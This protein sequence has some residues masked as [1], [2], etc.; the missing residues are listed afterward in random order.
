MQPL[1]GQARSRR[2]D[3]FDI[4]YMIQLQGE[5]TPPIPWLR[6]W[7]DLQLQILKKLRQKRGSTFTNIRNCVKHPKLSYLGAYLKTIL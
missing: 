2:Y 3:I 6:P 5:R 1:L 7:N 4:V